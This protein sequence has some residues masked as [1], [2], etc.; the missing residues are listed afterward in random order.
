MFKKTL[1]FLCATVLLW[2]CAKRQTV[3]AP[4]TTPPPSQQSQQQEQQQAKEEPSVRFENWQTVPQL[5]MVNF[6]YDS[7]ELSDQARGILQKNATYLKAN[8]GLNVLVEGHCDDRGTTEYNL[9]LGQ[10]R[11][12]SVRDYYGQLGVSLAR[13]ATI[14][15]GEEQPLVVGE[16]EAAWAQNRRAVTRVRSAGVS[17]SNVN[18]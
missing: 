7:A 2:G 6:G 3:K 5:S 11:A 9:A 14:S 8:T 10:R 4:E 18:Q 12:A 13:I 17:S 15:Y 16:N 1:I